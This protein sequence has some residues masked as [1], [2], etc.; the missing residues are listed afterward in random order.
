LQI[1]ISGTGTI[2]LGSGLNDPYGVTVQGG[3]VYWTNNGAGTVMMCPVGGCGGQ[4]TVIANAQAMPEIITSDSSYVYWANSANA[5][6]IPI[7]NCCTTGSIMKCPLAGCGNSPIVVAAAQDA[8]YGVAVDDSHIYWTN[9]AAG[10]VMACP[11][12]GCNGSPLT[13]AVGQNLPVEIAVDDS[14]LYWANFG[15]GT[16]RKLAKP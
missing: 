7:P 10:T 1:P 8:P 11:L 4:P 3:N 12:G 5:N 16:I 2:T 14:N 13:L 6:I 9:A 15:D